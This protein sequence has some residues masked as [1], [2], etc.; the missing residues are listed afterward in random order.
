MDYTLLDD[1]CWPTSGSGSSS[2][3]STCCRSTS[4]PRPA[5]DAGIPGLNLDST[6]TS[7]LPADSSTATVD[8]SRRVRLRIGSRR[9]PLQLSARPGREAVPVRRQRDEAAGQPQLQVRHRRAARLQPA[10]AERRA[11]LGRTDVHERPDV[12]RR[13]RRPRAGHVPDRRRHAAAPVRQRQ[14][15]CARAAVAPLLLRAGHLARQPPGPRSA[16]GCGSTSSIRRRSTRPGNAGLPRSRR[17]AI[18]RSS[19]SATSR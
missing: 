12:A 13:R 16:T 8:R 3:R 5:A 18:S 1:R 9:Q 14:H 2:T 17:P 7:G 11:P 10:R 19:A 15:R 4:A 6:F